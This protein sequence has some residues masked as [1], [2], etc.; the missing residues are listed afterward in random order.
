[1]AEEEK[2]LS[3]KVDYTMAIKALEE[4]KDMI[5]SVKENEK[6]LKKQLKENQISQEEYNKQ[7][8][9][10][11]VKMQEYKEVQSTLAKEVKNSIKNDQ[12]RTGSLKGLRAELSTLTSRFDLLSREEREN[13]EIGGKLAHQINEVTKEIKEA[14]EATQRYYRNVGNYENAIKNAVS[15]TNPFISVLIS[16][17]DNT[18]GVTGSFKQATAALGNMTKSALAFIATPIGLFLS[19]IAIALGALSKGLSSSE[20]QTNRWR[21]AIAPL[22][23][24]LDVL[25]N[26]ITW[27]SDKILVFVEQTGAM[28]QVFSKLAERIPVVGKYFK[29]L[30][31]VVIERVTL[32][33]EQIDYE[34][35][36]RDNIVD[37]A[38]R[39]NEI[40]RLRAKIAE[41]DKYTAQ[42]R[43]DMIDRVIA[44]ETKQAE[45]KVALAKQNLENLKA[46]SKLTENDAEMNQ[47]LVEAEAAVYEA[48]TALFQK[49]QELNGQRAETVAAIEAEI[50]AMEKEMYT[51]V[52]IMTMEQLG[53]SSSEFDELLKVQEKSTLLQLSNAKSLKDMKMKINHEMLKDDRAVAYEEIRIQEEKDNYIRNITTGVTSLLEAVGDSSR[54]A[55]IAAKVVAL[56][57]IAIDTGVAISGAIK[58]AATAPTG[59]FGFLA[60]VGPFISAILTNMAAAIKSVK[61]AKFATGGDVVGEGTATSDSIPAMLSNGESVMTARA[62]SMFAPILSAFNQAGGRVPIYGQQSGNQ[63]MGEDMLAKAFAK[64]IA[65]MPSPV[66]SVEEIS[67]VSNRVRVIENINVI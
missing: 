35:K 40:A 19:A 30:N 58:A 61:S 49:R 31:D 59:F 7:L 62:T 43:L 6:E 21:V 25:S 4:Y 14:E 65:N 54:E 34:K 51:K 18:D 10:G 39:E 2:I 15:S 55:A 57:Q 33:K 17:A 13:T 46:E 64:G 9:D 16:I 11:R 48:D 1:M 3:I 50:K 63:A 20:S 44:L 38:K 66:V 60:T 42:E 26:A 53:I 45:E 5:N 23:V 28:L 24:G 47:K 8:A 41:K 29:Q 32:Q 37:T 52:K 12:M 67:S 22:Q 56:A 27:V 36:V